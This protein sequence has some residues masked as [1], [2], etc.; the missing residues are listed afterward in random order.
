MALGVCPSAE[1]CVLG[2]APNRGALVVRAG[3]IRLMLREHE[4]ATIHVQPEPIGAT[5]P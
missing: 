3:T 5:L 4:A 1:V 2:R